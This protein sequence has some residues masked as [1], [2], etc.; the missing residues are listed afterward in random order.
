M[1]LYKQVEQDR[2]ELLVLDDGWQEAINNY[3]IA[4]RHRSAGRQEKNDF[5][6]SCASVM[7]EEFD[8]PM[9]RL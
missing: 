2:K 4:G 8:V 6:Y 9:E 3:I 1:E 5:R 7:N